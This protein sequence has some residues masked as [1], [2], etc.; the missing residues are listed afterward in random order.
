M[1]Q[2]SSVID[3]IPAMTVLYV[4]SVEVDELLSVVRRI[5][6]MAQVLPDMSAETVTKHTVTGRGDLQ[7]AESKRRH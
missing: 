6:E 5:T 2:L 1:A 4:V 3:Q 7:E